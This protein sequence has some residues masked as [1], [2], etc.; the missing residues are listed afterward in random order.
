MKEDEGYTEEVD[1]VSL[2]M[3]WLTVTQVEGKSAGGLFA[4]ASDV[5][6]ML[7][8]DGH[9]QKEWSAMGYDGYAVGPLKYGERGSSEAILIISGPEAQM[10]GYRPEIQPDRVTRLDVQ[11]TLRWSRPDALMA[12]RLHRRLQESHSK[13][14]K[15]P[16]LSLLQDQTGDTLYLGKRQSAVSLR[17]YDKSAKMGE[18]ELGSVWRY[19]VQYR[20][21]ASKMAYKR[22]EGQTEPNLHCLGLVAA[23]FEKRGIEVQFGSDTSVTAIEVG[24]TVTTSEGRIAW[25][26]KCVAPVVSQLCLLGHEQAV[27]NALSLRGII[28]NIRSS[29]KWQ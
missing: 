6:S 28:S 21:M 12:A 15:K 17:F 24:R 20:S 14:V 26:E 16:F 1:V 10:Y 9:V 7:V 27:I 18:R 19:E 22:L 29:G 25:L 4:C 8:G 5:A 3:D 23:E 13:K 11:V 2:G